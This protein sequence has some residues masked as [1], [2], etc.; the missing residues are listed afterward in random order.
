MRDVR[1]LLWLFESR[2]NQRE[3]EAVLR[4]LLEALTAAN[5]VYLQFHKNT[6]GIYQ[7]GVR[8]SE[9]L[10]ESRTGPIP[11]DWKSIPYVIHDGEGDCEDLACWRTA[12][13]LMAGEH[14]QPTFTHRLVG[15]KL[16]YHILVKR[17]N[18]SIEDPSARLGM[19]TR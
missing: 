7:S 17:G 14:A 16:L 4:L 10:A 19:R 15:N 13:L 9:E 6:P 3:S 11:E 8:Y 2:D 5:V 18:G 1:F 12:E